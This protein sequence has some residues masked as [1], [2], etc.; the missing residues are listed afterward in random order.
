MTPKDHLP[1]DLHIVLET[2]EKLWKIAR[3]FAKNGWATRECSWTEFEIQSTDADLLLAPASPPLLSGGVSDDP[4]AVDR[5]LTLLDSAAIPY[6]YEVYDE[7][8]VLIRSGP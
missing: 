8:D 7:A 5:I 1:Y 2:G 3:L 6:A 4:E